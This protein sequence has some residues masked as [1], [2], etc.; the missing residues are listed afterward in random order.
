MENALSVRQAELSTTRRNGASEYHILA[1][2]NNLANNYAALR[3]AEEALL[4]RKD[5]YAGYCRLFGED[6]N[7][8][9]QSA[10][11]C[12]ISLIVSSR[13]EEAK[14]LLRKTMP[15]TRRVLGENNDLTLRMKQVY[16]EALFRDTDGTLDDLREA[17]TTLEDTARIARRVLGGS[18]PMVAE[19]EVSL[20][21]SQAAWSARDTPSTYSRPVYSSLPRFPR[22]STPSSPG[23]AQEVPAAVAPRKRGESE[24]SSL[25][26]L[27]DPPR[28]RGES[29]AGTIQSDASGPLDSDAADA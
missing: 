21:D 5:V 2:Q 8:S 19:I 9:V 1:A 7:T 3:R 6:H 28:K 25:E 13:F 16:A 26:S 17:V 11:N 4:I 18:H 22:L 12:A 29:E 27:H 24:A 10:N 23:S 15:V 20:R 14:A